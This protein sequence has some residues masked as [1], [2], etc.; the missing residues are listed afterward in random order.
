MLRWANGNRLKLN[1]GNPKLLL[2]GRKRR[3]KELV[4]VKVE[5]VGD[6]KIVRSKAVK[7]LGVVIN[8]E[9]NWKEQ[10]QNKHRMSE[11][12]VSQI[13]SVQ[14]MPGDLETIM[15]LVDSEHQNPLQKNQY[16]NTALHAA[17]QGGSLDV[18]KYFIN[19]R[20]CNPACLGYLGG[21]PLHV[22]TEHDCVKYLVIE[23]QVE[24]L[25]QDE[26]R[27]TPLHL[28]YERGCLNTGHL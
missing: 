3:Q 15:F 16:G 27:V 4:Q 1:T 10:E 21:T 24:P 17:A 2:L 25:C 26:G 5:T 22:A 20:D 23:Q 9:L 7:C 8:D 28:S 19:E 13:S 14:N 6:E 11:G 18:L 12:S